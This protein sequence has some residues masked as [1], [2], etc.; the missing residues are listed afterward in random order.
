M[1]IEILNKQGELITDFELESNPFKIGETINIYASGGLMYIWNTGQTTN[2]INIVASSN[3]IYTVTVTDGFN[4]DIIK[5]IA[6]DVNTVPLTQAAANPNTAVC[7][8]ADVLLIAS[9]GQTYMWSD[10]NLGNTG[11]VTVN[12]MT[13]TTYEVTAYNGGCAGNTTQITVSI[14]SPSPVAAASAIFTTVY[15]NTTVNLLSTGSVGTN[16]QWDFNGD[17]FY[18]F[19]GTSGNA[20][21]TFANLGV[22]NAVLSVSLNGCSVTDTI[23]INVISTVSILEDQIEKSLIVYPNPS[24]GQFTIQIS[25]TPGKMNVEMYNTIGE[26]VHRES[27]FLQSKNALNIDISSLSEGIYYAHFIFEGYSTTRKIFITRTF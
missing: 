6:V 13:E 7:P 11:T 20:N 15:P 23:Q 16:Y 21:T 25:N 9:G 22:Y 12:P 14:I 2:N 24:N 10:P 5:S 4:C 27:L 1:K 26:I 8:G 17:G 18:E 3:T 19:T